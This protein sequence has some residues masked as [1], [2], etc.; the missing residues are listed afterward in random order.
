MSLNKQIKKAAKKAAKTGDRQDLRDFMAL[1]RAKEER[2]PD[3]LAEAVGIKP[4]G[5]FRL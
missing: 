3:K 4:C 5:A 1:R 2:I